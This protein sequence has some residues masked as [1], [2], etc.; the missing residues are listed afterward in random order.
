[1]GSDG[2]REGFVYDAE[3]LIFRED[4]WGTAFRLSLIKIFLENQP[5]FLDIALVALACLS[6]G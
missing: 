3:F 1:M 2:S 4:L 5:L 6:Y